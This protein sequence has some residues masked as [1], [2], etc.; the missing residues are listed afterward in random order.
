MQ[1]C[2]FVQLHQGSLYIAA[3]GS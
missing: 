3:L 1:Y 2:K